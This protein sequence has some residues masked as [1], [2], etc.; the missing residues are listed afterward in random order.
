MTPTAYITIGLVAC[1]AVVAYIGH[2]ARQIDREINGPEYDSGSRPECPA[3]ERPIEDGPHKTSGCLTCERFRGPRR[4][5]AATL[6]R[7]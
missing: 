5:A 3:C 1:T 7:N 6:S 2:V 4:L